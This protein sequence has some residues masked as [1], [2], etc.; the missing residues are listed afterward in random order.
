MSVRGISRYKILSLIP[1]LFLLFLNCAETNGKVFSESSSYPS[2]T[3]PSEFQSAYKWLVRYDTSQTVFARID[4]PA[5]FVLVADTTDKF[6]M[7]L[8]HLPL[9]KAGAPVLLYNGKQKNR[10]DVHAAVIDIDPGTKDLQQCADAVMR[11]RAEFLF[12]NGRREEISFNYTSGDKI[13]YKKWSEGFRPIV[14]GNKVSWIKNAQASSDYSTFK[15]YLWN[16]FNY[17]GSKS[18][19]G[20]MKT[21]SNFKSIKAGDVFII[22]G[23]PGHAMTVIETALN[24]STGKKVFLLAQSY[25][26]AQEIHVVRNLENEAFSPWFEIPEGDEIE[27]PEWTFG[28]NDLKRWP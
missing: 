18:L 22:G 20:E 21:V 5:G 1:F 25:M 8:Q 15:N 16:V 27:T 17:A 28:K 14:K 7:W 23:F 2:R 4:P 6:A 9:K 26:P 11:L 24:P 19:S 3:S 10:Q 12:S 13:P